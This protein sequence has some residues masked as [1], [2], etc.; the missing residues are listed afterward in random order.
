M[1]RGGTGASGTGGGSRARSGTRERVLLL[2]LSSAVAAAGCG[3]RA[4][5]RSASCRAANGCRPNVLLLMVDDL[6]PE[7]GTLGAAHVRSP[8]I[9]ELAANGVTFRQA[10]VQAP[11]CGASR[12]SLLTGLRPTHRRF[13]SFDTRVDRDAPGT[14]TLADLLRG[15]GYTTIANGKILHWDDDDVDGWSEPPW[16]VTPGDADQKAYLLPENLRLVA[17][18]RRGPAYEAADV[19]D[20]A[21]PNGAVAEKS[22]ADLRRLAEQGEPF[23]LAAGFWK[24][25]LPFNSPQRYWDLYDR[26]QVPLARQPDRPDGAPDAALH[27][28]PELRGQYLGIPSAGPLPDDLARTLVHGYLAAVSYTDALVGRVLDELDALGL[29]D[30]TIVVLLGDHGFLLGDHGMWTKHANF[31]L[32]LRTPLVIRA[33]GAARGATSDA[34]VEAVDL[35]PTLLELTGVAPPPDLAGLSLTPLL[36]DPRGAGRGYAVSVWT[37]AISLDPGPWFGESIRT[38]RWLYTEWRDRDGGLRARMLYDHE[39]DPD[40]TANVAERVDPALV[41]DLSVQLRAVT[42]TAAQSAQEEGA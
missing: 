24:P 29:A 17:E 30:D 41:D 12:A 10:Y 28:S 4:A 3:D 35:V 39:T 8:R 1:S 34:I 23:L 2:L 5:D 15:A 16:R 18:N 40:E 20:F 9:D 33:P 36:D 21:Y 25:H 37:S 6:R 32:A 7:L 26:A 42:G 31:D 19:D 14:A 27:A 38:G 13:V 22:I 11:V